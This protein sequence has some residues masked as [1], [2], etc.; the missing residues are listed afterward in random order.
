MEDERN[1]LEIPFA[2]QNEP[3]PSLTVE[4]P[5]VRLRLFGLN[6]EQLQG[7]KQGTNSA[8]LGLLGLFGGIAFSAL[9]TIARVELTDRATA[10]FVGIS[11]G[12]NWA[13]RILLA[14]DM[15]RESANEGLSRA[16]PAAAPSG[17]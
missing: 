15:A 7:L 12:I 9:T 10:W 16:H 13:Q 2:G 6:E 17:R 4:W 5:H 1:R 8:S 11:R 3:G 14:S